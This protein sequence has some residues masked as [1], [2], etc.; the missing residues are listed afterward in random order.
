MNGESG[1][2][3]LNKAYVVRFVAKKLFIC[4]LKATVTIR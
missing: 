2:L 1:Y 3:S 4:I